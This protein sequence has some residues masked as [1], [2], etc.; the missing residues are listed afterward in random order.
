MV[1]HKSS[2]FNKP[3]DTI[4]AAYDLFNNVHKRKLRDFK[5][6]VGAYGILIKEDEILLQRHPKLRTYGLPGGG[7]ELGETIA[8]ALS[9][10]FLE[11]TGLKVKM[12]KLLD[13]TEDFFTN[14][15]ENAHAILIYYK[16]HKLGGKLLKDGNS[17]DTG[18]VK[19]I[20]LSDLN[21][22]NV[23]RVYWEFIQTLKKYHSPNK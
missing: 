7:V 4:I 21:K 16:V 15:R 9:R 2:L 17:L 3:A 12:G 20:R 23:Q 1:K 11:E 18:E 8:K 5:F 19:F 10:E 13:I 6:R 22:S 14:D